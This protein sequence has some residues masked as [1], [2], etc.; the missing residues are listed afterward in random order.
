MAS[1]GGNRA[2]ITP[3]DKLNAT[4]RELN[5]ALKNQK[6][7]Q[8]SVFSLTNKIQERDRLD[9]IT[10]QQRQLAQGVKT[11]LSR[12]NTSRIDLA[13]VL[14]GS[15]SQSNLI[16]D[17]PMPLILFGVVISVFFLLRGKL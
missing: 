4:T 9:I 5:L 13:S 3:Q 8:T 11:Q 16:S 12:D 17:I 7:L 14:K 15:F 1:E 2:D 10:E 6:T